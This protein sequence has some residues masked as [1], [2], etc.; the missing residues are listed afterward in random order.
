MLEV[1]E[2]SSIALEFRRAKAKFDW[3]WDYPLN[4][5][6]FIVQY[7][8]GDLN[9]P[10]SITG[11]VV[12]DHCWRVENQN[13]KSSLL[14]S[15]LHWYAK[16]DQYIMNILYEFSNIITFYCTILYGS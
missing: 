13:K 12:G 1:K 16:W 8:L 3:I 2:L 10:C 6:A 14:L 15:Y 4:I 9:F 5:D 7:T 11:Y